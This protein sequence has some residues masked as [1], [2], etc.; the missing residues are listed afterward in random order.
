MF[1]VIGWR[2]YSQGRGESVSRRDRRP[3]EREFE[4]PLP[5][6]APANETAR[7]GVELWE[8]GWRGC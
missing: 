3:R 4:C 5:P 8:A 7:V 1:S 2:A 6:L